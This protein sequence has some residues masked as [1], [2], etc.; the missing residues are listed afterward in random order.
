MFPYLTCG[1]FGIAEQE[2]D[3][4]RCFRRAGF[5]YFRVCMF[6]YDVKQAADLP[7]DGEPGSNAD[8]PLVV[9]DDGEE[10]CDDGAYGGAGVVDH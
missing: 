6:V 8:L 10:E 5:R 4:H 7:F 1:V 3:M 9:P 2:C